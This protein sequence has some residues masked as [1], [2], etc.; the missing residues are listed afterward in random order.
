M[1]L[2]LPWFVSRPESAQLMTDLDWCGSNKQNRI[3]KPGGERPEGRH[4]P[5]VTLPRLPGA[6]T[7]F[8]LSC[9]TPNLVDGRLAVS[10]ASGGYERKVDT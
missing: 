6:L 9:E 5:S 7:P 8:S 4:E 10:W 3:A 2:P 1:K